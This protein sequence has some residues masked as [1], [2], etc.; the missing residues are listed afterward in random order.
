MKAGE[1]LLTSVF[2]S[3]TV[4]EADGAVYLFDG[5]WLR[6]FKDGVLTTLNPEGGTGYANGP[7]AKA[8][9]AHSQGRQHGL[10]CDGRGDLYV[11]DK[12][13]MAIRKVDLKRGEVSTFAGTA[14]GV[15]KTRPR[16]G[17]LLDARFHPGGG[18]NMIF[19]SKKLDA[20]ICRSDDETVIR[21]I[22]GDEVRTFG[23]HEG[24][25]TA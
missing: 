7:V 19:Y 15:E 8:R 5:G 25:N 4:D 2:D 14:P 21:I 12:V 20:F 11:A 17:K 22:K 1:S 10:T 18:P 9:F 16:D 6:R 3:V 23:P 24:K 13:N